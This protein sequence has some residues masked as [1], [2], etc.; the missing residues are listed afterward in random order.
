MQFACYG[1]WFVAGKIKNRSDLG[2]ITGPS[3]LVLCFSNQLVVSDWGRN[4]RVGND[5]SP[6]INVERISYSEVIVFRRY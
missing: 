6:E 5:F 1:C 4:I 3:T 2:E